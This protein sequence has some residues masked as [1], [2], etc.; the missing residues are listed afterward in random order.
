MSCFVLNS[1]KKLVAILGKPH[2]PRNTG[3]GSESAINL[4]VSGLFTDVVFLVF[5]IHTFSLI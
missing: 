5:Y 2:Y 1:T 4:L 3:R